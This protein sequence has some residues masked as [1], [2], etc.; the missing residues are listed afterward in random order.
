MTE[1]HALPPIL[2]EIRRPESGP[3]RTTTLRE[4]CNALW[5]RGRPYVREDGL[6]AVLESSPSLL[7]IL[8]DPN[9]PPLAVD[10]HPVPLMLLIENL[11]SLAAVPLW[12]HIS[13]RTAKHRALAAAA[14][15]LCTQV[16]KRSSTL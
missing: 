7:R 6:A 10:P 16:R 12:L 14:L 8:L 3:R 15:W 13:L 2:E 11:A 1:A 4:T 5:R 9:Q